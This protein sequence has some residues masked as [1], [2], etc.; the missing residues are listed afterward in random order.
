[1]PQSTDLFPSYT[2][3]NVEDI[4]YALAKTEAGITLQPEQATNSITDEGFLYH[5]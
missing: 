3:S 5:M 1:M 2:L 4:A